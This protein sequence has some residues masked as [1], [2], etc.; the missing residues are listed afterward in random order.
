MI[1]VRTPVPLEMQWRSSAVCC[2][3]AVYPQFSQFAELT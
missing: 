3:T 1:A 2:K